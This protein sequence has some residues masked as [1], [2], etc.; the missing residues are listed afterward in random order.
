MIYPPSIKWCHVRNLWVISWPSSW[1]RET[2]TPNDSELLHEFALQIAAVINAGPP[3]PVVDADGMVQPARAV[4]M[5]PVAAIPLDAVKV[6][7]DW[8]DDYCWTLTAPEPVEEKI[9]GAYTAGSGV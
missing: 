2:H 9:A 8:D 4:H 6:P 7:D 1:F 5:P 3:P